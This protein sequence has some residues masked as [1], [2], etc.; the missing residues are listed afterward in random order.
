M[1]IKNAADES[2]VVIQIGQTVL[3]RS[4]ARDILINQRF[5]YVQRHGAIFQHDIVECTDIKFVAKRKRCSGKDAEDAGSGL[6]FCHP[7]ARI[8]KAKSKT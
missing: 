6:A 2:G 1:T 7:R 5:Q 4:I 8:E 3:S